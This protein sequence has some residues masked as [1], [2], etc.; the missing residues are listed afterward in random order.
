MG[1]YILARRSFMTELVCQEALS[2]RKV[3]FSCHPGDSMSSCLTM[4]RM[5]VVITSESVFAYVKAHQILP[6]V[7]RAA[8]KEILGETCLS[9]KVPAASA[10]TQMRRMKRV[11]LSQDSSKLMIRRPDSRSGS[12]LSAYCWRRTRQRSLF[13]WMG[14][15]LA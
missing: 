1:I 14:T 13:A 2:T 5:K 9:V 4:W 11:W 6:S 12:I 10:G 3:V 7:S 8:I 15:D